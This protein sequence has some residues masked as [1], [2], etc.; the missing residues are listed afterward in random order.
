MS[1]GSP[2]D[3]ME[4]WY[5]LE[6]NNIFS[7]N[8]CLCIFFCIYNWLSLKSIWALPVFSSVCLTNP[9]K[10]HSSHKK[11]SSFLL[12]CLLAVRYLYTCLSTSVWYD[13][14][15]YRSCLRLRGLRRK[16]MW[17]SE[18]WIIWSLT[19]WPSCSGITSST[20]LTCG[21]AWVSS[22][23]SSLSC[24]RVVFFVEELLL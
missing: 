22:R 9:F 19:L 5:D 15:F 24:L 12:L 20:V 6:K 3:D 10:K 14:W 4:M 8:I 11:A 13:V 7:N 1:S 21:M 16:D 2:L 23:F 17:V 18:N